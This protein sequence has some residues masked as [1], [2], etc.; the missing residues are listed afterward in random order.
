MKAIHCTAALFLLMIC[1]A[2]GPTVR[3]SQQEDVN[4]S[5]FNTFAYLPNTSIEV[6]KV[7]E[8]D[9]DVNELVIKTINSNLQDAGYS[10]NRN[11]PDLLVLVSTKVNYDSETVPATSYAS[12]PYTTGAT[13]VS[14]Y[15]G[16][17]YYA[18]YANYGGIQG[19]NTDS[20]SYKNGTVVVDII[21]RKTKKT[22]WKGTSSESLYDENQADAI[23]NL[24]NEIFKKYPLIRD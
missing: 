9:E 1:T 21:N 18:D 8:N 22:V 15:Y 13:A 16:D 5:R 23:A 6:P 3:T 2:C 4:L 12:Y 19:Y 20:Y 10:I 24:V 14:T 17:Y 11:N 7:N